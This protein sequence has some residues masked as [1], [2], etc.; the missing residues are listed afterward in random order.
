MP[1]PQK[2]TRAIPFFEKTPYPPV[3]DDMAPIIVA[4]NLKTPENIGHLMRLAANT[5]C[6]KLLIVQ[7]GNAIRNTKLKRV[8]GPAYEIVDWCFCQ[9]SEMQRLLP[10]NYILTALETAND[11]EN[12]FASRLPCPMAL[13]VGN[14]QEGLPPW[15]LEKCTRTVHI[16]MTGPVKSMNVSHAAAVCL[17][18]WIRQNS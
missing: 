3:P 11:S 15:A 12:L 9:A 17:F 16:P 5:G 8:A 7:E 1:L 14:E 6:K 10:A 4:V 2:N 13:L 18:E